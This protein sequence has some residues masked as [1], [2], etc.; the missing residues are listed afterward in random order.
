MPIIAAT[1][2]RW[3]AAKPSLNRAARSSGP[4]KSTPAVAPRKA[5]VRTKAAGKR[6]AAGRAQGG[7]LRR[8]LGAATDRGKGPRRLA[9]QAGPH[10]MPLTA[11]ERQG[12]S[13]TRRGQIASVSD[14]TKTIDVF[15]RDVPRR[16][17]V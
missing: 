16:G 10:S 1:K 13:A 11:F 6:P 15:A 2:R 9:R 17:A 3:A 5:A 12:I 7:G 14:G 8:R 4:K